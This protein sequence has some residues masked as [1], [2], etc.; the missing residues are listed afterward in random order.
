MFVACL[1][2]DRVVQ[3]RRHLYKFVWVCTNLGKVRTDLDQFVLWTVSKI[4]VM[5]VA[6]YH[7]KKPLNLAEYFV[8]MVCTLL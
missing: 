5:F 7:H 1:T 8:Q 3:V 4:L 6:M 2:G